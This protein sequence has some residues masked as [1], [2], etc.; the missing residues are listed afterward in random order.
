MTTYYVVPAG[1]A[2]DTTFPDFP[3]INMA[4]QAAA[5]SEA[6]D[7]IER[8]IFAVEMVAGS[9]KTPW[10]SMVR[11]RGGREIT[12]YRDPAGEWVAYDDNYGV[13]ASSLY[14]H[15]R[16][17]EE[18]TAECLDVLADYEAEVAAKRAALAEAA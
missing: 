18:A 10:G 9:R 6:E 15:G 13:E 12:T 14:G 5:K 16:T 1:R 11:H 7:G 8:G 2:F 3:G 17:E 4:R